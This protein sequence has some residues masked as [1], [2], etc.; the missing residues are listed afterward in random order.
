MKIFGAGA[1]IFP[2]GRGGAGQGVHP[3]LAS[4]DL[5]LSVG[6]SVCQCV[7]YRF[8]IFSKYNYYRVI[9]II[10]IIKD[11]HYNHNNPFNHNNYDSQ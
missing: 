1:A 4:L 7:I 10:K 2:R 5:K 11:D 3:W 6:E 8:Q 9:K